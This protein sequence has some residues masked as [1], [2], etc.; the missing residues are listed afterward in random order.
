M[1]VSA[2]LA[3]LISMTPFF[4][5]SESLVI[6]HV[7]SL[8]RQGQVQGNDIG[9]PVER[10]KGHIPGGLGRIGILMPAVSKDSASKAGQL[11][12]HRASDLSCADDPDGEVF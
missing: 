1:S 3:Q 4:H 2:P 7:I 8:R 6:D 12:D 5:L 11:A 9:I 10:I